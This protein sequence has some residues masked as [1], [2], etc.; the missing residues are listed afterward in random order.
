MVIVALQLVF[1]RLFH[2]N[3]KRVGTV[4]LLNDR[5]SSVTQQFIEVYK[6][7]DTQYEHKADEKKLYKEAIE[8]ISKDREV[9]KEEDELISL[10]SL[11]KEAQEKPND[12]K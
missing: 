9:K 4:N 1:S 2:K 6:K 12:T 11:F 7:L 3:N 5:T 8:M 10:S